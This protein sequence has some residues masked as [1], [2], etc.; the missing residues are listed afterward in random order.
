MMFNDLLF[1]F[2]FLPVV[3]GGFVLVPRGRVIWLLVASVVF[4]AVAGWEHVLI[5]LIGTAWT[6]LLAASPKIVGSRWRLWLAI[7]VPAGL[8]IY[9]KYWNFLLVDVLGIQHG[10][11]G[12]LAR[13]YDAAL[14]AGI[15]FFSFHLMAYAFDRY[16]GE[17]A[18]APGFKKFSL[19]ISFFPHLVAGP[20]LRY[21]EVQRDMSVLTSFRTSQES[22]SVGIGYLVAGLA[23]KTLL[24]DTLNRYV[25]VLAEIPQRLDAIQS[26]WLLLAYS[27][28]IYFDFYGYSLIAIGLAAMMGFHFPPNFNRPYEAL[29]PRDFWR[30]WHMTLSRW[31]M[32]YI[33]VPLG[34]RQNYIRNIL[35]VFALCG[36]WHGAGLNFV[37]WG[38]YHGLLIVGYHLTGRWWDRMPQL[39]QRGLTF[40]LVSIGWLLFLFN[41]GGAWAALKSLAGQ[42]SGDVPLTLGIAHW[43]ILAAAIVVCYFARFEQWIHSDQRH[44]WRNRIGSVVAAGAFVLCLVLLERTTDF[45]YFRF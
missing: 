24:A 35:I 18:D 17:L 16:R 27:F 8:L 25:S 5:L 15:S 34:G 26:L 33:Y 39:L 7:S 29:N 14:P 43:G 10:A 41:F 37:A 1:L 20:I 38:V 42:G 45:I 28:Q 31:I 32:D 3:L 21:R 9:F 2:V 44:M 4:Y 36:L 11:D 23:A 40:M 22:W 12:L 13:N 19:F 30:R 6:W